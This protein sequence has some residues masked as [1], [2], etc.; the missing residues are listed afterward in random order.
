MWGNRALGK[1]AKKI[2]EI[3]LGVRIV[4]SV[5]A[6]GRK[7]TRMDLISTRLNSIMCDR[8]NHNDSDNTSDGGRVC[9]CVWVSQQK[10]DHIWLFIQGIVQTLTNWYAIKNIR[11]NI[12]LIIW[13]TDITLV[14][15]MIKSFWRCC[16][17]FL[18]PIHLL[19]HSLIWKQ[20]YE[21]SCWRLK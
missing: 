10:T 15:M 14:W 3:K 20:N 7:L 9:V 18:P 4:V 5:F 8:I 17:A 12:S 2:R 21:N 1:I 6:N 13:P 16:Q 19:R 11:M